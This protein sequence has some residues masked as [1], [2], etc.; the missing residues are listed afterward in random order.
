MRMS[1]EQARRASHNARPKRTESRSQMRA[2]ARRRAWARGLGRGT[3]CL[4]DMLIKP[5]FPV[6]LGPLV[7]RADAAALEVDR[8]L[9]PKP[10][11]IGMIDE[12]SNPAQVIADVADLVGVLARQCTRIT[13]R[14][15]DIGI[16]CVQLCLVEVMVPETDHDDPGGNRLA[17]DP[18]TATACR[19]SLAKVIESL[20]LGVVPHLNP[21]LVTRTASL[22]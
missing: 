12:V 9:V 19:A 13:R 18:D 7:L 4:G 8:G 21:P 3:R 17:I 10:V 15:L 11:S 16:A 14:R 20:D 1:R 2:K 6:G 5:L 22:G